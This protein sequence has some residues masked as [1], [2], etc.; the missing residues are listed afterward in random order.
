MQRVY[1]NL[2]K[3]PTLVNR[4][5][6]VLLYDNTKPH[7]SRITQEKILDFGWSLLLHPPYSLELATSDFR[8]F[9]S[10]QNALNGKRFSQDHA[11]VFIENILSW[12]PAEFLLM[13]NQATWFKR[14]FKIMA[15]VL[16][17]EIDSFLNYS[18]MN[19]ILQKRK[20]FMPQSKS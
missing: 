20:L 4:R 8:L 15:N 5:N 13:K 1:E 16:L 12:K 14:W 2:I 10:L 3:R 11:N 19:Y 9:L 17:I 7:S 6:A 18:W